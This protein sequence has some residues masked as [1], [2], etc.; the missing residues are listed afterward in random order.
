MSKP[1]DSTDYRS[2]KFHI[3]G[4]ASPQSQLFLGDD[5]MVEEGSLLLSILW[6]FVVCLLL[7]DFCF[8]SIGKFK[9]AG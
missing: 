7:R 4:T 1:R 9:F 6:G 2:C 8:L 5:A 3:K